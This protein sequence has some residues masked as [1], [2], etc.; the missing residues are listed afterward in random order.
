MD[1]LKSNIIKTNRN[2]IDR[3]NEIENQS[4]DIIR[5]FDSSIKNIKIQLKKGEVKTAMS[6][7]KEINE[8]LKNDY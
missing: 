3:Y 6:Y 5:Y 2:F 4:E 7:L 1:I 8:V